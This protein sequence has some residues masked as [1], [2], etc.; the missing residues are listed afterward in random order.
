MPE[1]RRHLA[2]CLIFAV[3]G[4]RADCQLVPGPLQPSPEVVN[5]DAL[6]RSDGPAWH[7]ERS[8]HFVLYTEGGK[9]LVFSPTALLKDL[10]D[11]WA[12]DIALLGTA[13]IDQSP[14]TVLVTH[15]ATRFPT[16]LAPSSRGV[17]RP[18]STAGEL[19]ILV[20][21]DSIRA[22]TRHE[23]M[24]V[25]AQRAWGNTSAQWVNEGVAT[26]ADGICQST[27][28]LALARDLLRAEPALTAATL[29][30][31]FAE[32]ASPFVGPRHSRYA[33]AASMVAFVYDRGGSAALREMWRSGA[34]QPYPD[35]TTDST[36]TREWRQYVERAA[37]GQR[38][39]S[40]AAVN[41]RGCD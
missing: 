34:L 7:S 16:V 20:H 15:S 37:A 18:T 10:E 29:P 38:G 30:L 19:I 26:W 28:V 23:V 36:I 8:S 2:A 4:A 11:A 31:R 40:A 14:I 17:T 39:P 12:H 5:A 35:R 6:I 13:P 41:A 32:G 25:V 9:G 1:V 33:L 22:Y 27:S 24:H 21:N 3:T